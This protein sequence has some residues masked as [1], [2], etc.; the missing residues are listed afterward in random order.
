VAD[1]SGL[2]RRVERDSNQRSACRRNSMPGPDFSR[3]TRFQ[4][5]PARCL[6]AIARALLSVSRTDRPKS[7][8]AIYLGRNVDPESAIPWGSRIP[9]AALMSLRHVARLSLLF[10]K[11]ALSIWIRACPR[12]CLST[13]QGSS[14]VHCGWYLCRPR[15][16]KKNHKKR[17]RV[18]VHLN[19]LD[20]RGYPNE[21]PAAMVRD[22]Q[23]LSDGLAC[24]GT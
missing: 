16:K 13:G 12:P 15:R 9:L 22:F 2:R 8:F 4:F 23:T 19:A 7:S 17:H 1:S 11:D 14:D 10:D 20:R 6:D 3:N 18:G 24:R 5:L 21:S